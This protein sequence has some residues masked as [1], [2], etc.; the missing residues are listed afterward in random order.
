MKSLQNQYILVKEGKI[1]KEHFLKQARTLFPQYINQYSTFNTAVNT[2]SKKNVLSENLGVVVT[3]GANQDWFKIFNENI[4]EVK[5]VEKET[6]KEV[7]DMRTRGYDYTDTKKIDNIYSYAFLEG[8]Y[9]EIKDPKNSKKTVDEIK[10]IV[11]K[12]LAKDALHYVKKGAFGT[13]DIGYTDEAPALGKNTQPTSKNAAV[14]GG[15]DEVNSE[16]DVVKNSLVGMTK[17][18]KKSLKESQSDK[19]KVGDIVGNTVQGFDFKVISLSGD[20]MKVKNTETGKE[21][22]TYVDNMQHPKG[23]TKESSI[24][25]VVRSLVKQSLK[26]RTAQEIDAEKKGVTDE[27]KSKEDQKKGLDASIAAL[28]ARQGQINSEKPTD[29]TG[30]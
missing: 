27:I 25:E 6:T 30:A 24:R 13:K 21:L 9:T 20:K 15:R 4:K 23:G 3:K 8:Y 1:S 22:E 11:A 7:S 26:E 12:N 5:A 19:I 29:T 16:S 17:F 14:L 28:K 18:T 2:L 10:D